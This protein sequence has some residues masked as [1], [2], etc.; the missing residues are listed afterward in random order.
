MAATGI[1]EWLR[2]L[3]GLPHLQELSLRRALCGQ[4]NGEYTPVHLPC[5]RV[6]FLDS[7]DE[8]A[9]IYTS[10]WAN[11]LLPNLTHVGIAMF[12]RFSDTQLVYPFIARKCLAL[13]EKHRFLS[14]R[15]SWAAEC[16]TTTV[17]Q[18]DAASAVFRA[19]FFVPYSAGDLLRRIPLSDITTLS[20]D[21]ERHNTTVNPMLVDLWIPFFDGMPNLK[22][23]HIHNLNAVKGF[24]GMVRRGLG[25]DPVP[26]QSSNLFFPQLEYLTFAGIPWTIHVFK[27]EDDD[28]EIRDDEYNNKDA[29]GSQDDENEDG[30]DDSDDSGGEGEDDGYNDEND[31]DHCDDF[32]PAGCACDDFELEEYNTHGPGREDP[33]TCRRDDLNTCLCADV[34]GSCDCECG[35][36]QEALDKL[37][38]EV[39]RRR[40]MCG[41]R[42]LR[43]LLIVANQLLVDNR[44][45]LR[46]YSSDIWGGLVEELDVRFDPPQ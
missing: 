44:R 1:N 24:L 21:Y 6:L 35:W 28:S 27:S 37:I 14:A 26:G 5:L 39:L 40:D 30:A 20:I 31:E 11:L 12:W 38:G 9:G 2:V 18:N 43:R 22:A 29:D 8:D 19:G 23:L 46:R 25:P 33:C 13:H 34:E 3:V 15:F 36:S 45:G 10:F 16:L 32:D 17:T 41:Y 7:M 42:R 4:S